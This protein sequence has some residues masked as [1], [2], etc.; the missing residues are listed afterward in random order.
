MPRDFRK[1]VPGS[2][3]V[4]VYPYPQVPPVFENGLIMEGPRPHGIFINPEYGHLV[5]AEDETTVCVLT[6]S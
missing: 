2:E 5:F 6:H 3:P 1:R 4:P